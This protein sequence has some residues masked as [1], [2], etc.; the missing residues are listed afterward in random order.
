MPRSAALR[1]GFTMVELLIVVIIVGL[2]AMLAGPKMTHYRDNTAV[3]SARQEVAAVIEAA[4][5]GAIQRGRSGKISVDVSTSTMRALVDT[6][7]VFGA[8]TGQYTIM[9]TASFPQLYG[10]TLQIAT[11]GDSSITF[12]PRGL[13]SPRL[14][15]VGRIRVVGRWSKDS[16]CVSSFGTIL[17]RD[18]KQ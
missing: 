7:A 11:A 1:R 8:T 9:A 13:A 4:R 15:R 16:V 12:D 10:V 3:R 5:A 14:G 6:G 18:C 2:L 17:P